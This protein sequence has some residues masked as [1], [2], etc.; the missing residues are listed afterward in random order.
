MANVALILGVALLIPNF[1]EESR[2][3]TLSIMINLQIAIFGTIGLEIGLAR[4]GLNFRNIFPDLDRFVGLLYDHLLQTAII[5]LV[6][7]MLLYLGKR[8]LSRIE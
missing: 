3:H 5:S 8:K 4:L 6:G 2:A 1:S 7:V